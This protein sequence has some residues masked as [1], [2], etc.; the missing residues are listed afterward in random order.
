MNLIR[1]INYEKMNNSNPNNNNNDN[2]IGT[3]KLISCKNED[4]II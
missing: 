4:S 1:H 3:D 2:N